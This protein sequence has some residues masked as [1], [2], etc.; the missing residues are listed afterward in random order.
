MTTLLGRNVNQALELAHYA[1]NFMDKGEPSKSV[2]QR[3]KMFHTDSVLC[4]ISA[5]A[6]RT[7]APTVL[8]KEAL[9]M[10][11]QPLTKRSHFPFKAQLFGQSMYSTVTKAIAANCSAVREW[12]SNG[13]VFGFRATHPE[14]QAGE[15]GHNDFYPVVIAAAEQNPEIDGKKALKAM[16][17]LDEIRGRLAE[18]FSLKTYKIDHVVHGAIGSIVTYGTLLNATPEQIESAIGMFVA[19]YIPFRAIRAGHQLSDSKGASAA[20]ST[21]AAIMALQRSMNGFIGPKDIFRNPQAIFRLFTNIRNHES[22]FDLL[23]GTDGSDFSVMGMHFKL[24][25]YEHQS[26]GAIQAVIDLISKE[27]LL[28]GANIDDLKKVKI[29]IYEPAFGIIGDPHKR[30]PTTRQSADHSMVFIISRLIVKAFRLKGE[31]ESES[32]Q[33]E[34]WKKLILLPEDYAPSA[35]NDPLTRKVMNLIEFVHGG[36]KYDKQYPKGIPTSVEVEVKDKKLASQLVMFPAGHAKCKGFDMAGILNNK[37]ELMA[38]LALEPKDAEEAI[39]KLKGIDRKSNKQLCSLYDFP[40]KYA[41]RSI[42]ES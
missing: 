35:I 41:E 38:K 25:L 40:I 23:L 9:E 21:E 39:K 24:G 32:N 31:I 13:T 18:S 37:F 28:V 20:L 3:T 14:H 1:R 5:L 33:S 19:H 2:L 26:A 4:G 6:L 11:P 27:G 7:N 22:P 16:V 17:L 15:F 10:F 12:D 30:D 42:D 8:R 36:E 29:K 34:I